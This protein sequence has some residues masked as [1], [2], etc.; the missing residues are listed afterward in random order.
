M[1]NQDE[2]KKEITREDLEKVTDSKY[3]IPQS[4]RSYV[5]RL[6]PIVV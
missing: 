4:Y 2:I 6:Y 1:E 3:S 5:T